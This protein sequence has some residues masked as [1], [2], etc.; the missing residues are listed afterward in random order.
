MTYSND[1]HYIIELSSPF[2]CVGELIKDIVICGTPVSPFPRK[3][4]VVLT[5][6][7]VASDVETAR[8]T[9]QEVLPRH[10]DYLEEVLDGTDSY[11][12]DKYS[13]A[14][15]AVSAQ[16]TQLVFEVSSAYGDR[17]PALAQQTEAMEA[18]AGLVDNLATWQKNAEQAAI[19]VD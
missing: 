18:H 17:C 9:Y 7:G 19:G 13:I 4:E 8:R 10:F 12:G 15:I 6:Q 11:F 2:A 16:L 14:D 1:K 5:I 3:V